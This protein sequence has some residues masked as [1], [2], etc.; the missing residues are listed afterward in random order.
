MDEAVET[1]DQIR[2]S[3]S[4]SLSERTWAPVVRVL[5]AVVVHRVKQSSLDDAAK[6]VGF[7]DSE[8]VHVSEDDELRQRSIAS[9]EGSAGFIECREIGRTMSQDD[10]VAFTLDQLAAT[11]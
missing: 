3:I 4:V 8:P 6:V 9:I 7:L 1:E 5:T 2:E 10:V 11:A